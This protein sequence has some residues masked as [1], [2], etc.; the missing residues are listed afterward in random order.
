[1]VS[2][3]FVL[4]FIVLCAQTV[5]S[6]SGLYQK[7]P[8][9]PKA[10]V[11]DSQKDGEDARI[12]SLCLGG[13]MNQKAAETYV[14]TRGHDMEQLQLSQ[15]PYEVVPPVTP[16]DS[17]V[18]LRTQFKKYGSQI[19]KLFIYDPKKDW[20]FY[21]AMMSGAQQMGL[22][23][24]DSLRNVLVTEF[25]WTGTVEDYRNKWTGR[26]PAYDWALQNLMPNCSKK[27]IF[28]IKYHFSI[29]LFDYPMATKGFVF[30]LDFNDAA[31]TAEIEKILKAGNYPVGT[32]LMGYANVED[33]A[34]K[35]ANKFGI[36]Y[37]A[38]D[39][40]ANGSFWSSFPNKTYTQAR[41]KESMPEVNKVYVCLLWS[42][43]DNIQFDQ[44]GLFSV[45]HDPARGSIPVGTPLNPG[46]QELNPTLMDYF[47]T[48][49]K[50]NDELISGPCGFQFIYTVFFDKAMYPAWLDINKKWLADAGFHSGSIWWTTYPTPEYDQYTKSCGLD[51]LFHNY[52]QPFTTPLFQNGVGLFNEYIKE[53]RNAD[54]VYLDLASVP[55]NPA[56]PQFRAEKVITPDFGPTGYSKLK[57]VKDSL[58]RKFPGKY[59]FL[60]PSA[61]INSAKLWYKIPFSY[62]VDPVTLL[63]GG[64]PR[65]NPSQLDAQPGSGWMFRNPGAG[66]FLIWNPSYL[67]PQGLGDAMGRRGPPQQIHAPA[68][69]GMS[70]ASNSNQP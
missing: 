9:A 19:Q 50:P 7:L 42:D 41:S 16:A 66:N 21:L 8:A 70:D 44:N 57:A 17:A 35:V 54:S 40:Y 27:S 15:K 22:P 49:K 56:A 36:G 67:G 65:R 32:S 53:R 4:L 30:W 13:L 11:F 33:H 25:G 52:G 51:G 68:R 28:V 2:M 31:E 59:V 26:I 29:P 58:D 3:A 39:Y 55:A 12:I 6:A 69:L 48:N 45:W 37:V 1:M 10:Y 60:L 18:G 64:K 38:S 63:D 46:L 61:F 23:I 14:M 20:T 62:P 43:G 34:N 47:Y 5:W 24:T